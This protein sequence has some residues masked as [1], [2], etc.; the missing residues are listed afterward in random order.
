M[1]SNK[2]QDTA[3]KIMTAAIDLMAERGYNGVTTEEIATKAGFSEKTLFRH[4]KS[5]QNLLESAFHRY[6]YA[7]EMKD[8]FDK[9]ITWDLHTDLMMISRNYHRIMHQNRK[10]IQI[11]GRERENLPG[12]QESTHKHPQQLKEFLTEYFEEMYNKGKI[13]QT[14]PERQ[15]VVFLYM[16][17]GA[18]TGRINNDPILDAFSI[19]VFIEESVLI[20]TRALTP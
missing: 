16:H 13:I 4:F 7:E 2:K 14:D 15:A 10:L 18:A 1:N 6:H 20:F 17:Y 19:E 3:D 11:S 5:K 12:F 9:K 8:L